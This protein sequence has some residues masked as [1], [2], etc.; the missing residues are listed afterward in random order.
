MRPVYVRTCSVC[1]KEY[2]YVIFPRQSLSGRLVVYGIPEGMKSVTPNGD[3]MIQTYCPH[4]DYMDSW[5][6]DES[7]I[8]VGSVD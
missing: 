2:K 3:K 8:Q 7:A 4:C 6:F 5:T 1:N